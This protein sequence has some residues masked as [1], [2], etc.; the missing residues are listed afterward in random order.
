[1]SS[2]IERF[3]QRARRAFS[4]YGQTVVH[5]GQLLRH[6]VY[7]R[8]LHWSVAISFILSLLSGF[9]IYS[10]WLFRWLTPLFGGGP[11]TRFLHPWFGLLFTVAFFF[12]FLNW[13]A[14]MHWTG[15]DRR[16]MRRMKAY[17]SNQ[18][19]L[20][21]EETGFFNGGQKLYFWTIVISAIFF[22]ITGFLLWFG[23]VAPRWLVVVSYVVHDIAALVML[24]GFIIH[25]YEGTAAQ[26][27]TFQSMTDGTVSEQWAWTHHPAW[28]AEVTGRDPRED[29]ENARSRQAERRQ[30]LQVPKGEQQE[31]DRPGPS[32]MPDDRMP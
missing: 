23:D 6:P 4:R 15:A 32:S 20:E 10:P 25:I 18:E 16:W 12:Q 11:M 22:L 26:P 21:A 5:R 8:I 28:Y 14:P 19:S 13:F 31:G 7:T 30:T 2:S 1:M 9:A 3:D 17:V 29:Y 24:A 27:G